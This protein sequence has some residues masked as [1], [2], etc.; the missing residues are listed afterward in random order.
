[1]GWSRGAGDLMNP[2]R[3]KFP[4]HARHHPLCNSVIANATRMWPI[5]FTAM[6]GSASVDPRQLISMQLVVDH[7]RRSAA[8][9]FTNRFHIPTVILQQN[10]CC[11]VVKKIKNLNKKKK[12][13]GGKVVLENDQERN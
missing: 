2:T 4:R 6:P 7:T 1:M 11:R 10:N 8:P 12:V 5:A 13:L 3:K 9:D